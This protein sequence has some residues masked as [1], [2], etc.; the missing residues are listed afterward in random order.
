MKRF[1]II[2][3]LF[4]FVLNG[5]N[6]N[7]AVYFIDDLNKRIDFDSFKVKKENILYTYKKNEL[8]SAVVYRLYKHFSFN[9]L[10]KIDNQQIRL[11][12]TSRYDFDIKPN[13]TIILHFKD[14]LFGYAEQRK[15]RLKYPFVLSHRNN[16]T[17]HVPFTVELYNKR[18]K[19]FDNDQGKCLK[20]I[21]KFDAK[22]LYLYGVNKGYTHKS[23]HLEWIQ[24]SEVLDRLFFNGKSSFVILRPDGQ[25]Y[26][27]I[28]SDLPNN[29]EKLLKLEDWSKPL[30]DYAK[31]YSVDNTK[32]IGFFDTK[33]NRR[34]NPGVKISF[35]GDFD[36]EAFRQKLYENDLKY[37]DMGCLKSI[38]F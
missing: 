38:R 10:S 11:M 7:K 14:T 12:L 19:V 4:A 1:T 15:R 3:L 16:D 32:L 26:V 21:E 35:G 22:I 23:N 18:R 28:A 8:D 13:N 37:I 2:F 31:Q 33:Y 29:V 6:N 17:I 36:K 30:D 24:A 20:K 5:Q 25:F 27:S 9:R 34:S